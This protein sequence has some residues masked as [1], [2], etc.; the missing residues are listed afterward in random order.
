MSN[1]LRPHALQHTRPPC[2]SPAP[3]VY[4]N[5]CPLSFEKVQF[6][7]FFCLF[8]VPLTSCPRNHCQIRCHEAFP[9][10]SYKNFIVLALMFESLIHIV[11][12]LAG[13]RQGA[14][15]CTERHLSLHP[16]ASKPCPLL[17]LPVLL[18]H[19]CQAPSATGKWGHKIS[20][21]SDLTVWRVGGL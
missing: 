21:G 1:S 16:T 12:I 6:V 20:A 3:G 15:R 18:N 14:A 4:P 11:L 5:P 9:M 8:P 13:R 2:P 7:N 17:Q 10:F 19:L